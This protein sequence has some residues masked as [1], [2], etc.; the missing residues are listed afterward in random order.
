MKLKITSELRNELAQPW[1]ELITEAE[2]HLCHGIITVGDMVSVTCLRNGIIPDL[3]IFDY[4]TKRSTYHELDNYLDLLNPGMPCIVNPPS[5][6]TEQLEN[7]IKAALLDI[8]N[9]QALNMSIDKRQ[10]M[11]L[12]EEDLASIMV[13]KYAPLNHTLIY[14]IPDVG[15]CKLVITKEVK[16]RVDEIIRK[17][18]KI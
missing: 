8:N 9:K 3:M 5:Y 2:L 17:F 1:G 18:D 6:I 12:G 10:I 14:G 13:L 16:E 4:K 11:V 15:M 7:T